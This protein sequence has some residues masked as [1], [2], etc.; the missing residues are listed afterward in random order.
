MATISEALNNGLRIL[1]FLAQ[2]S[3]PRTLSECA[4]RLE[5]PKSSAHRLLAT[6]EQR[7]YVER[8]EALKY[9]PSSK[10]IELAR[11]HDPWSRLQQIATPMM[12]ELAERS[13]ETCHLAVLSRGHAVYIGKVNSP[14]SISLSSRIGS[15]AAL[16]A[17][18]VG[19]ALLSGL[20]MAQV[21]NFVQEYGLPELSSK[22]ITC[23]AKLK[24]HLQEIKIQGY[25]IDD[26]EEE[27]G[28][29]CI[30]APILDHTG[31]V[32]AALSLSGLSVDLTPERTPEL[33]AMVREAATKVSYQLGYAPH[34]QD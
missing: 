5:L 10:L 12:Q 26:E 34:K 6:L 27:E 22:T 3:Q 24:A 11:S 16:H 21:D 7:G 31:N 13:G 33:A 19:K 20:S 9:R 28:V 32:I 15:M 4:R 25:A 8:D 17:S 23:P 30:G 1:E 2:Q 29:K 18:A 14:R